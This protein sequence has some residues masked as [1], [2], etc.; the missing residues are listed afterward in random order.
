[1]YKPSSLKAETRS[2]RGFGARQ[3]VTGNGKIPKNWQSFMRDNT[4]KTELFHF[5]ADMIVGHCTDNIVYVT[6]GDTVLCN[7]EANVDNLAPFYHEEAD[8]RIVAHVKHSVEKGHKVVLIK[9]NDTDILVIAVSVFHRLREIGL[10]KL[11]LEFGKSKDVRW[12]PVH[13]VSNRLSREESAGILFFM[14][15]LVAIT[16]RVSKAKGKSRYG[17]HGMFV[18]M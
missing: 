10:E 3:L 15:F 14:H 13:D 1:M 5:L 8:T 7:F 12:I 4:N 16:C 6:Q 17:K 9:A 11:W 2:K 18:Q